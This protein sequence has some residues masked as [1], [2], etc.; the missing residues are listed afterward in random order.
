MMMTVMM[1]VG[2]KATENLGFNFL[3]KVVSVIA[4]V[5]QNFTNAQSDFDCPS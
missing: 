1:L 2:P 5:A 3:V 4:Y